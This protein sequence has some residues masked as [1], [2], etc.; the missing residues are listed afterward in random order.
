[1]GGEDL[2]RRGPGAGSGDSVHVSSPGPR[3]DMGESIDDMGRRCASA[4]WGDCFEEG[5]Y[6]RTIHFCIT[7]L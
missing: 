4:A 6:L 3:S 7:Q 1:M 5:S 2:Q